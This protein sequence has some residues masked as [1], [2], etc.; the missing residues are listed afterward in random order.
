MLVTFPR[1]AM[2]NSRSGGGG[3]GGGGGGR[4][5]FLH[6]L[7]NFVHNGEVG[8]PSHWYLFPD[9]FSTFLVHQFVNVMFHG[10]SFKFDETC[11]F[12][13]IGF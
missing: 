2:A 7:L 11:F 13:F 4:R 5:R 3:G 12:F 10:S 9:K 1:T 8:V 6:F